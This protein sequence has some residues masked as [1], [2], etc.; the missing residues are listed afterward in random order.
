[1]SA[2]GRCRW[3]APKACSGEVRPPPPVGLRWPRWRRTRR[4]D[5][6]FKGKPGNQEKNGEGG[7]ACPKT[8]LDADRGL[9]SLSALG[10][11]RSTLFFAPSCVPF[12]ICLGPRFLL[13]KTHLSLSV[14]GNRRRKF[15]RGGLP[16]FARSELRSSRGLARYGVSPESSSVVANRRGET[17]GR[18]AIAA[19]AHRPAMADESADR[20]IGAARASNH[21]RPRKGRGLGRE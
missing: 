13:Q 21:G 4:R 16:W 5:Q 17:G 15:P 8:L 14:G 1:M 12:R 19:E 3:L 7:A 20:K 18:R 10:T 11:T 6:G 2:R 9:A